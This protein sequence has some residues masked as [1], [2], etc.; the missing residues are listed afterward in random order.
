MIET[1]R[2]RRWWFATHPEFSRGHGGGHSGSDEYD[3]FDDDEESEPFTPEDVDA[4]VDERLEYERNEVA[5]A[6]LES[7]KFWFGTEFASKSPAEQYA[8]LRDE[9]EPGTIK[10]A[11]EKGLVRVAWLS[12]PIDTSP[13]IAGLPDPIDVVRRFPALPNPIDMARDMANHIMRSY[14]L[15]MNDP[16][17]PSERLGR[18]LTDA[19]EIAKV[20]AQIAQGHAYRVHVVEQDEF[21]EIKSDKEFRKLIERIISNP[22]S[23]KPLQD[24]RTAYWD[25]ETGTIVIHDPTGRDGGTAF[26]TKTGKRFYNKDVR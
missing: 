19:A 23:W 2:Q 8:L 21:S 25:K 12:D 10:E 26:R 11:A 18:I 22:S 7:V 3:D 9:D 14:P 5:I 4:Y 24:G 6:L 1:D 15:F 20:A 13:D 16:N 17:R